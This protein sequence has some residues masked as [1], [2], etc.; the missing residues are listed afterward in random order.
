MLLRGVAL[1]G[2]L[3]FVAMAAMMAYRFGV[4]HPRFPL[5]LAV[6]LP[7]CAIGGMAWGLL[8]WH[9]NERVHRALQ[10]RTQGIP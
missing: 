7:L 6:A 10:S 3:V 5:L 9:F 8:T 2:G 4:G 1:W